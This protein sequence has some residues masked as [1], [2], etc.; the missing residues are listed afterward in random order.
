MYHPDDLEVVYSGRHPKSTFYK[1]DDEV[2]MRKDLEHGFFWFNYELIWS[3]F[4]NDLGLSH[5]E[6]IKGLSIWLDETM[7]IKNLSPS[8]LMGDLFLFY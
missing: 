8:L 2:V 3:Y 7:N 6:I 4:L 1:K 5:G